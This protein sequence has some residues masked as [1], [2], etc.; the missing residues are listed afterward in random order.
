MRI[1]ATLHG[2]RA[3]GPGLRSVCWVRG[4]S[5]HCPGCINP[6]TW[7]RDGG[8]EIDWAEL[9]DDIVE[10]SVLGTEGVTISGGEPL[11]Q[12]ASL[13]GLLSELR[14]MRPKWSVG[15]F[16]G[17][18]Q[19]EAAEIPEWPLI[20]ATLDFAVLGR[21]DRTQPCNKPLVSSA[22]QELVLLS[23]RYTLKDFPAQSE[24]VFIGPDG[25]CQITGYPR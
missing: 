16:S 21:Y 2:S 4:C 11:D 3:N 13:Y 18:T 1:H 12:P 23:P 19:A 17:Y 8:F 15:I 7:D 9:A 24:E 6:E 5:L 25:L 14:Y 22:N 20:R 10:N